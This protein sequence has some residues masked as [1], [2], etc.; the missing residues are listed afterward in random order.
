MHFITLI[1]IF[2]FCCSS[3]FSNPIPIPQP[4]PEDDE[5]VY[6][7]EVVYK[8]D[9]RGETS[10]N[11]Q[12]F[13]MLKIL[14]IA[15]LFVGSLVLSN[16]LTN[17]KLDKKE[18]ESEEI[19]FTVNENSIINVKAKYGIKNNGNR[20]LDIKFAYPFP[21]EGYLEPAE[22][23]SIKSRRNDSI[24]DHACKKENNYWLFNAVLEPD[25]TTY[26][27]VIYTQKTSKNSFKYLVTSAKIWED[28][29]RTAN[30][31]IKLPKKYILER[32]S[33]DYSFDDND[34]DYNT[35]LIN[36]KDFVPSTDLEFSWARE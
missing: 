25:T 3:V 20:N 22:F 14:G 16:Y 30:F 2:F 28:T 32:A 10:D 35:Y 11:S 26:I 4:P 33:F 9:G 1:T 18:F 27:E 31:I 21:Q 13:Q 7:S 19:E 34:Q 8:A 36:K 6:K 23:I 29:I 15:G 17:L 5:D 24:I 12:E